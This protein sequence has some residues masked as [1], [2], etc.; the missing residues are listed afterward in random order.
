MRYSYL[1]K[2]VLFKSGLMKFAS[3]LRNGKTIA[4]LRYHSV[5]EPDRNYYVSPLITVSPE[6]FENHVR[7]FKN[8]FNIISLDDVRHCMD[9]Q[10]P[11]PKRAVVFTFDDGYRDNY[12][13]YQILKKY[14]AT[15]T[16]YIASACIDNKETLWLF[17]IIYLLSRTQ[18]SRISIELQNHGRQFPLSTPHE[19]TL[20]ARKITEIIKS[21]G[22]DTRESIRTQVKNQTT[23][24]WDFSQKASEV[25][26][27]W[28]QVK[29]MSDNG[30]TIGGHTTTHL[31]LPNADP[32]D[33][34]REI[35]GCKTEIS[36]RT[37]KDV[38]HFSYPN[39]GKYDYYNDA[40]VE[41]VKAA[42]Y[43]TAT[44]SNNGTATLS[45]DP[46]TLKRIRVSPYLSEV[47]YQISME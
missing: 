28:N 23:D 15:G 34:K 31:N 47:L 20:S 25:M 44:T 45:S 16:F 41:M 26:L 11:F 14:D 22:L 18:N 29:E 46:Y 4:I 30:M 27:T 17:E 39:G 32:V 12:T 38:S 42:G 36:L 33:A 37:G 8:N 6:V 10:M 13:A 19:R 43:T 2:K 3:G 21:N 1:I 7:Y 24:V 5:V 40:I 35:V 9:H